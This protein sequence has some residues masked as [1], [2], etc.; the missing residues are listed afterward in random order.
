MDYMRPQK[1]VPWTME[2]STL[3]ASHRMRMLYFPL[4]YVNQTKLLVTS[5]CYHHQP[6]CKQNC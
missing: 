1:G 2:M 6:L 3:Q 4:A 5:K